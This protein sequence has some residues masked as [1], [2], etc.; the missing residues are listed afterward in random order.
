MVLPQKVYEV[1]RWVVT[2]VIPAAI[3]LFGVVSATL[4]NGVPYSH[5]IITIATATDTFL[6]VVFG[7]S[8]VSYELQNKENKE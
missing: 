5:E 8:K 4:P 7:I 1:L 3:T 6:G 2:I